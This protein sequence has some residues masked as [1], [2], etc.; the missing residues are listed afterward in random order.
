MPA[1]SSPLSPAVLVSSITATPAACSLFPA[2]LENGDTAADR[3]RD[4]FPGVTATHSINSSTICSKRTSQGAATA[5][6]R[7]SSTHFKNG[8]AVLKNR[9]RTVRVL[10]TRESPAVSIEYKFRRREAG[11]GLDRATDGQP[12]LGVVESEDS[13]GAH[14]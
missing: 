11:E 8:K 14:L 1:K 10:V 9:V 13:E 4:Y 7:I 12:P 5:R 6:I 3:S 2:Q